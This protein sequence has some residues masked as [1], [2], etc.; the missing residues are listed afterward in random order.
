MK[1]FAAALALFALPL[2][3]S[4]AEIHGTVSEGASRSRRASP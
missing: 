1:R 4:A 2:A 3:L